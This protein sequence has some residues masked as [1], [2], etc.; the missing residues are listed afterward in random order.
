MLTPE[1]DQLTQR[2]D[3]WYEAIRSGNLAKLDEILHPN[4][5]NTEATGTVLT[6]QTDLANFESGR[7]KVLELTPTRIGPPVVH[8]NSA[9]VDGEDVCTATFNGQTATN[10]YQW[11]D[12]WVKG[13]SGN[14]LCV[15]SHSWKI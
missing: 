6:K 10:T 7:Y 9:R 2:V 14:W 4:Y 5:T 1:Q 13:D 8:G 15:A 11:T 12:T 3:E